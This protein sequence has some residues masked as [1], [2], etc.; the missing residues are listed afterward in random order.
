[1]PCRDVVLE[2]AAQR[3]WL[4]LREPGCVPDRKGPW[5]IADTAKVLR[6]FIAA[7]PTAYIDYITLDTFGH[8]QIEHGPEVLQ[9]TDG[10]SMSVGRKH[11]SRVREAEAALKERV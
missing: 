5:P 2:E 4:S 7:R 10:R 11:N 1:M 9:R 6:E 8:P 3:F